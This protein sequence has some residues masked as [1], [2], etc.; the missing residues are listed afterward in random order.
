MNLTTSLIGII[1]ALA[2][3]LFFERGKRQ[4]AEAVAENVDAKQKVQDLQGQ[5][6]ENTATIKVEAEKRK[7]ISEN[8]N[9]EKSKPTSDSELLDFFKSIK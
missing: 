7:E 3:W 6:L 5:Q 4:A 1:T 8:A 2:G 9:E